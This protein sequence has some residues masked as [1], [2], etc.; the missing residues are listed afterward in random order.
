MPDFQLKVT[1]AENAPVRAD[2]YL[3]RILAG[4]Y[5]RQEIKAALLDGRIILKGRSLKPKSLVKEGDV[6]EG[7][8]AAKETSFLLPEAIP[9]K[10]IYED[11]CLL[12]VDKPAGMVVHPGAGNKKGTLVHAL[13]GR[14]G[15]AHDAPPLSDAGGKDRPGIVHSLD[16]DASG[17]MV[18]A[19]TNVCH[20][21][22][23]SQFESRTVSKVYTALV[24][25][26]MEF[27]QGH[28]SAPIGRHPRHR[29]KMA[30]SERETAKPAETRYR[31][32]K[33]YPYSTLLEVKTLTGRTHQIRVHMAHLG[34]PLVGDEI[35]GTRKA[36][37][38]LALHASKIEFTHPKTGKIMQ[39]KCELPAD[40][41]KLIRDADG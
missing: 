24:R 41:N 13:L 8:L 14:G 12:V 4:K 6:I 31:V 33:R 25:G 3:A 27:E 37:E 10:V 28:V 11:E 40:F 2:A 26:S 29:Q 39:F 23:A 16:K 21:A 20:R 30:V 5:S 19:K 36:G 34:H 7:S 22:L 9:V 17:V 38:R 1:C 18:I 35:Y 15:A 32:I